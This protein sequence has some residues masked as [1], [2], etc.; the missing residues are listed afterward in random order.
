M[1][2]Q[3]HLCQSVRGPLMN[4]KPSDWKRAT[5]WMTRDDGTRFTADELKQQ[6]LDLLAAGNEVIPIGECDNFDPKHGCL[7]HDLK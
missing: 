5:K 3:V 1:K 2:Q 4:W 7:G 6:F